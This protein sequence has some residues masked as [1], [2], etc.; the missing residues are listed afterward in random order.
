MT[1]IFLSYS[2]A[3]LPMANVLA[4]ELT[5]L[6]AT[7]ATP[8]ELVPA[9]EWHAEI[10][11]A[12][13]QCSIFVAFIGEETSPNV[14]LELGYALGAAKSVMLV[15][16]PEARIP[17]DIATLPVARFDIQNPRSLLIIAEG[18]RKRATADAVPEQQILDVHGRLQRMLKDPEYLDQVSPR[19]F[20]SAV[21]SVFRDLGFVV[22]QVPPSHDGGYDILLKDPRS[23]V[24]AVVEVKKYQRS[25]VLGVANVRQ[26][27]GA[28]VV[29]DAT[30]GILVTT[31][32]FSASARDMAKRAPRPMLL[33]TL[34]DLVKSTRDSITTACS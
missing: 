1:S 20:E 7:V 16:G 32:R 6:G 29:A 33:L 12:I 8:D 24:L 14:M 18:I 11:S 9:S 17:F 5:K 21:S 4:E 13:R 23:S 19:E 26:L 3:N 30:C 10:L 34:E 25:G 28:M 22:D 31:S 15:G 27:V 2:R